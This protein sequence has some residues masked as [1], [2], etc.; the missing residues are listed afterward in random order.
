MDHMQSS[1]F[2]FPKKLSRVLKLESIIGKIF[3]GLVKS[4]VTCKNC[5]NISSIEEVFYDLSLQ[6]NRSS[7]V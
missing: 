7:N 4:S 5:N 6:I 2:N 3:A 1:E